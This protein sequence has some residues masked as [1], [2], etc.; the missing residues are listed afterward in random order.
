VSIIRQVLRRESPVANAGKHYPLPYTGPGAWG[1]GK[2]LRSIVHPLRADLPIYLGAEG[3]KNVALAAEVCDGWLPLYYS[4]FRPEVYAESLARAKPGFEIVQGLAVSI[5]DD[6]AAGLAPVKAM[7]GFYIGGMGAKGQNYHTKLMSRFGYEE[8]ALKIQEAFFEGRRDE[9][10]ALVPDEFADAISLV[11]PAERIRDRLAAWD[12]SPVSTLLVYSPGSI[13]KLHQV[14]DLVLGCRVEPDGLGRAGE[15]QRPLNTAGRF[16]RKA[17]GP[18]RASSLAM[19]AMPISISFLNA[20]SSG[21]ASAATAAALM[22]TTASGPLAAT[23]SAS[24]RAFS[25]APPSGVT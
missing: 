25:S 2:P 7:L 3:P 15:R 17:L 1:V 14:A 23:R 9:A 4:P 10:I 19:T 13:E 6:V 21:R 20:S 16:S 5:T 18:S 11:G 24:S 12:D 22:P 8:E